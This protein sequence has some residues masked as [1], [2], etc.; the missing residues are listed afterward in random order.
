MANRYEESGGRQEDYGR[1]GQDR[2]QRRDPS[3]PQASGE[4]RSWND[5]QG[6]SGQYGQSSYGQGQYGG[7]DRAG[8]RAGDYG[9]G[10]GFGSA[11]YGQGEPP[12]SGVSG[13]NPQ[14]EQGGGQGQG[15]HNFSGQ[16]QGGWG[17]AGAGRYGA[18]QYGSNQYGSNQY[19]SGPYG[20]SGGSYG[21]QDF[22]QAAQRSNWRE[23]QRFGSHA[24][25]GQ[26]WG[27]NQ[28]P[29]DAY[30]QEDYGQY[31]GVR[32][33]TRFDRSADPGDDHDPHYRNW[34]DKQL[35]DHDR[36]YGRWRTEQARRYDTD[37]ASWRDKRHQSF[38]NDFEAWRAENGGAHVGGANSATGGALAGTAAV[39]DVTDGGTGHQQHEAV[40]TDEIRR[41][42]RKDEKR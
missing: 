5:D 4:H 23:D 7:Y 27:Q 16:N 8:Y 35:S 25:T 42:A 34:R 9:Q 31:G 32:P 22:S 2:G 28:A 29:R 13:G 10:G 17:Q 24:S 14:H 30:G 15:S 11:G 12:Y 40:T 19:G 1:Y 6:R 33:S 21:Q 38:R 3:G 18:N 26:T 36:E 41:D 37:Y 20:Q 39:Q